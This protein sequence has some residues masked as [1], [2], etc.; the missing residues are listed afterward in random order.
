MSNKKLEAIFNKTFA[1]LTL[2]YRDTELSQELQNKYQVGQI[3]LSPGFT[4]MTWKGGGLRTN[5]RYL[6]ASAFGK[7]LSAFNANAAN[8][9]LVILMSGS[10]FKVLDIYHRNDKTQILLLNIPEEAIEVFESSKTNIEDDII[11]KARESFDKKVEAEPLLEL[12][13]EEWIDRTLYPVGM[14]KN[15]EF[16]YKGKQLARK[17]SIESLMEDK[18]KGFWKKLFGK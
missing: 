4:D 9:G 7:D 6:I 12:L 14:D 13:H 5:C 10:Y 18:P 1:G 17:S 3:L 8:F 2:F 16:F 15:G 11:T